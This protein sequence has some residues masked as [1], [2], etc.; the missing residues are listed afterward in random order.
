MA[1]SLVLSNDIA[2]SLTGGPGS[3]NDVHAANFVPAL[4]SDE[5]V[6]QYKS[7]LVLANLIRKLNHR[8]K[9]GDTIHIPTPARGVAV[10]KVAQSVVTLQPF[11]DASG[12][13]VSQSLSTS[14]RNT[15][16]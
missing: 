13:A 15:R 7:N 8:G 16:A 6:A 4:W 11:V 2:T 3:P 9:K 1:T 5:V 14:T 10:N 12:V